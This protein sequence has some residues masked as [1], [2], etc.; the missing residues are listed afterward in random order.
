MKALV[1][2]EVLKLRS[3]RMVAGLL[4]AMLC[5]VLLTAVSSVPTAR[6]SAGPMSLDDPALLSRIVGVSLGV[7]QVLMFLLGA[8][9]VTQEFRYGTASSTFLAAPRRARV[10][11]AK[12]LGV[13]LG[14]VPIAAGTLLV[15]LVVSILLIRSR[16]GNATLGAEL[17][18]VVG[19]TFV[20]LG[21]YG[22]IG[23][24]V[25]AL[26]RNQ[27]AAVIGALVW[28]LP[29]EHILTTDFPAV[30]RWTP[31]GA[32]FG[33]LQLGPVATTKGVLLAAPTSGLLLA[34]YTALVSVLAFTLTPRRDVL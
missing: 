12:W 6:A 29:V 24:G 32:T 18:P 8:L 20:V 17:W 3:T 16:G 28:M 30:G 9:A 31:L 34:A 33:L 1:D 23:V 13:M 15:S 10:L 22:V 26:V 27:T 7:P 5:L 25:G 14:S 2:A 19:A 11:L 21:V 4:L